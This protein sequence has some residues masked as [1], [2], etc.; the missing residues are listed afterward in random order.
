M[1][2]IKFE[3]NSNEFNQIPTKYKND[4]IIG[5]SDH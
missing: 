5:S 1:T 3:L 2:W 4:E